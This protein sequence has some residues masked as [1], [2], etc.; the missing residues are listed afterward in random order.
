MQ[1]WNS[2]SIRQLALLGGGPGL[3]GR[4]KIGKKKVSSL[5]G[6]IFPR[7]DIVRLYI[8]IQP[9]WT[10]RF[11]FLRSC[12]GKKQ[13]SCFSSSFFFWLDFYLYILY[14]T[15]IYYTNCTIPL[16]ELVQFSLLFFFLFRRFQSISYKIQ[17]CQFHQCFFLF[18][19]RLIIFQL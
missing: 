10:M 4:K 15:A 17:H 8:Y 3:D 1:H 5:R 7:I 11:S 13:K 12:S 9:I 2:P 16:A 19:S 14:A 18:L 6:F